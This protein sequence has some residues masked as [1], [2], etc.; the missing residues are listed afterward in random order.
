ML[1]YGQ[2]KAATVLR[3]QELR[4][5][6]E[7][8]IPLVDKL[9]EKFS[10][11]EG[12]TVS[13]GD[14]FERISNRM[15]SFK[16][17][18]DIFKDLTS[19]GGMFFDMQKKQADTLYGKISNLKDAY[20]LMLNDIGEANDGLLKGGVN[21]ISALIRNWDTVASVLKVV[22]AA[23]GAYKAASLASMIIDRTRN[24]ILKES[25]VIMRAN[26]AA[27]VIMSREQVVA[28][29]RTNILTSSFTKLKAAMLSNP[30]T[31]ILTGLA[32]LG[33]IVYE[34]GKKSSCEEGKI[35]RELY[36]ERSWA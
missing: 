26:A 21:A 34:V 13:A 7:A 24:S 28:A 3:G 27:N 2:V 11:L 36:D 25:I 32:A 8:G 19:S 10:K 4:Q 6:T 18:D 22:V 31:A 29:A 17:V 14:V 5:F 23:Y 9:A 33:T 15:V 12:K 1:A 35:S 16:D 30:I 20:Q